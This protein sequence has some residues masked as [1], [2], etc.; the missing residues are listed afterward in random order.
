MQYTGRS[1][2]GCGEV[3][4]VGKV[5]TAMINAAF[6]GPRIPGK[7]MQFNKPIVVDVELPLWR[8]SNDT[9]MQ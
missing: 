6:L 5:E 2:V 9:D 3:D 4:A 1:E 8:F 7:A